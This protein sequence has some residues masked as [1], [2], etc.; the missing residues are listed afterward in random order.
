LQPLPKMASFWT[1]HP[2]SF[3]EYVCLKSYVDAGHD[4]TLYH[5]GEVGDVPDGI[6][7]RDSREI[8]EPRFEIG[9]GNRHNNAVYSDIFR[10]IM[11]RETGAVWI[12]TDCICVRPHFLD[13]GYYIGFEDENEG[14]LVA[15]GVLG[16][17]RESDALA[18]MIELA[19][20]DAPIPPFLRPGRQR[21]LREARDKGEPRGFQDL[22]WGMSG[23]RLVT[24]FLKETGEIRQAQPSRVFYPGPHPIQKPLL[25]PDFPIEWL[26]TPDTLSV[27][28]YGR[29]KQ[30]L[31]DEYQGILPEGCYLDRVCRRHGVNPSDFALLV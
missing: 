1:G 4:V 5:I 9:P 29:T 17:P 28:V 18:R 14:S 12:D 31:Q 13:S 26:E 11:V 19:T 22:W 15:N 27:H 8:Y 25:R 21:M 16:L 23:P 6:H 7:L 10:L 24:H 30:L 3:I 2:M 20:S